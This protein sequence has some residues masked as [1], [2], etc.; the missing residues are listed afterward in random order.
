MKRIL[1]TSIIII[2]TASLGALSAVFEIEIPD[3]D[4]DSADTVRTTTFV[5]HGPTGSVDSLS[6]RF[7][8]GVTYLGTLEC[9]VGV[10]PPDTVVWPMVVE[11]FLRKPGDTGY[12]SGGSLH[13]EELGAYDETFALDTH[14]GGFSTITDGNV[15]QVEMYFGP[16]GF[17]ASCAPISPPSEGVV[18]RASVI[19][20]VTPG[21]PVEST[22]W[23]RI[24]SLYYA[25]N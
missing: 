23:G 14:N 16:S 22:T 9:W 4:G 10:T 15:I 1:T 12:W 24:K 6:V 25:P 21:T 13:F 18:V 17:V 19:I 7:R 5:Y 11:N 2:M 3:L 8:G 20:A